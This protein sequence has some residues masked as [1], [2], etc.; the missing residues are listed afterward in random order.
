MQSMFEISSQNI[1]LRCFELERG[2]K[3]TLGISLKKKK[4][5]TRSQKSKALML[6][7]KCLTRVS[8]QT[9]VL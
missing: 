9:L 7:K 2:R 8:G 6:S 4:N 5:V 1:N 3:K